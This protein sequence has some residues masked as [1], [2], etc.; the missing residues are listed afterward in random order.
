MLKLITVLKASRA[1][2]KKLGEFVQVLVDIEN[3]IC[4]RAHPYCDDE[5]L[6]EVDNICK[7]VSFWV[8]GETIEQ[9]YGRD[10]VVQFLSSINQIALA[11]N[12]LLMLGNEMKPGGLYYLDST[13]NFLNHDF[14]DH[15]FSD[16]CIPLYARLIELINHDIAKQS[17]TKELIRIKPYPWLDLLNQQLRLNYHHSKDLSVDSDHQTMPDFDEVDIAVDMECDPRDEANDAF[18][19]AIG[20]SEDG[21]SA[22]VELQLISASQIIHAVP[23]SVL[24]TEAQNH[25]VKHQESTVKPVSMPTGI[26][27]SPAQ[28]YLYYRHHQADLVL[29]NLAQINDEL[30]SLVN[31]LRYGREGEQFEEVGS[32]L[33]Q[34]QFKQLIDSCSRF[35]SL[36]S[37]L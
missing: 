34:Q 10:H 31:L 35:N 13:I 1:N 26:P 36:I 11:R 27:F 3:A 24:A 29:R 15:I 32:Q 16:T 6:E 23:E 17:D 30:D 21:H 9:R 28:M 12:I 19:E 18:S 5:L 7:G 20:T 8:Q 2:R 14:F 33:E 37:A 22:K 4:S 25:P